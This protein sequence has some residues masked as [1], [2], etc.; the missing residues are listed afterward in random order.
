MSFK[1]KL[2]PADENIAKTYWVFKHKCINY[3]IKCYFLITVLGS[4]I[5]NLQVKTQQ[6]IYKL[7]E[8]SITYDSEMLMVTDCITI[9]VS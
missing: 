1:G 6:K 9:P 7:K 4:F 5:T 2:T 8:K 3:D